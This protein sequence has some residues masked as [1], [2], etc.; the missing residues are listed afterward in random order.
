MAENKA[1]SKVGDDINQFKLNGLVRFSFKSLTTNKAKKPFISF[2][3]TQYRMAGK[4]GEQKEFSKT[5][6]VL[7]FDDKLVDMLRVIDQQVRVEVFGN[8]G[9]KVE[10]VGARRVSTP[11]LIATS[12]NVVEFLA[13]PFQETGK[14]APQKVFT[15]KVA[16][17]LDKE[18]AKLEET[19]D[20]PF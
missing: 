10:Q 19:D 13:I 2:L 17:P 3:L 15:P 18:I 9:I 11:T 7:V 6:Q 16:S 12:V 8:I 14:P 5:F 20:L 1:Y 4:V